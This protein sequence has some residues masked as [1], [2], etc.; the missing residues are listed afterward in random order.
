MNQ[1]LEVSLAYQEGF[2]ESYLLQ[3]A[4]VLSEIIGGSAQPSNNSVIYECFAGYLL[5]SVC[6]VGLESRRAVALC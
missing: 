2:T 3:I 4:D 1:Y 6:Y 5:E